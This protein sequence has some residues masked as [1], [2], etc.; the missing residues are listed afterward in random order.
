MS[1]WK[2][3]GPDNAAPARID[4]AEPGPHSA[5]S[6]GVLTYEPHYGLATKPFSLSTDPRTLYAAP[7]HAEA[8]D[9]LLSAIRR[10][11]GLIAVT[12][13]MGT[14]KTTLC[15]AALYQL[16][17]KTF[18]T[19]VPDPFLSREDLLRMMLVDFGEL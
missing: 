16:D 4:V 19:F 1:E 14:G 6:T 9:D 8:L 12:G 15:R 18:T 11:E 17:R 7:G 2:G 13:E 5:A 3:Y 10:R